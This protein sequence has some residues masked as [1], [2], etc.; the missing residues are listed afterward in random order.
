MQKLNES[1]EKSILSNKKFCKYYSLNYFELAKKYYEKYLSKIETALL[2]SVDLNNLEE[3]KKKY[4]TFIKD[5]NSGAIVLCLASFEGGYIFDDQLKS[6]GR[7]ITNEMRKLIP[8]NMNLAEELERLKLILSNFEKILIS[9]Q[10]SNEYRDNTKKEAICIANIIKINKTLGQAKRKGKTM[11][12]YADR[13]SFIIDRQKDESFKNDQWYKEFV[14]L[15]KEIK[16]Y[17]CN[18]ENNE[19][20][21]NLF[22]EIRGKYANIF[23]EI[24]NE[25]NR[26][27]PIN[28]INFILKN[29]PYNDFENDKKIKGEKFFKNYN[30]TL[31]NYLLERYQ[32]D[33]FPHNGNEEIKLKYC[34]AHEI[35]AKL[36]NLYT[37]IQ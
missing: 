37:R 17:D 34:K 30:L 12:R 14:N 18:R 8:K 1:G 5:I 16:D 29:H 26:L 19:D 7:G 23:D 2:D 25:F 3:Q 35:F 32:P 13:C 36:N 6:S 10:S 33:N 27:S 28:F 9:I 4:E 31:V 24:D 21:N 11:L 22:N 15:Y 20:Y